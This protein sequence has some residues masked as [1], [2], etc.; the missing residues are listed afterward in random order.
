MNSIEIIKPDFWA[1]ESTIIPQPYKIYRF[2]SGGSRYYF[3]W[4]DKNL[5]P[6]V[7][8]SVT[9]VIKN[10][11]GGDKKH[12][13]K[14]YGTKGY[15]F[16]MRYLSD[17]AMYGTLMH[18]EINRIFNDKKY[19][20]SK[21]LSNTTEYLISNNIN[22]SSYTILDEDD[23][24]TYLKVFSNRLKNDLMAFMQFCYEV[25][26]Q[27]IASE[28]VL[29]SQE[30]GYAGAIDLVGYMDIDVKEFNGEY[31]KSGE[32]KGLPK[33]T[34]AK[35]RVLSIVD[36]KSGR[37]GFYKDHEWQLKM[38][39]SM[40]NENFPQFKVERIFNWSPNDWKITPTYKLKDQTVGINNQVFDCFIEYYKIASRNSIPMLKEIDDVVINFKENVFSGEN[41]IIHRRSLID[42]IKERFNQ[43]DTSTKTFT[44][45]ERFQLDEDIESLF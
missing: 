8:Q 26:F 2:N 11:I 32:K 22:P 45:E 27:P 6:L 40:W 16:C 12:L 36:F 1:S 18:I 28:L 44:E 13:L 23:E 24:D 42:A 4:E 35:K 38:Y 43:E 15:S 9:S 3:T 29:C 30:N 34:I 39:Q 10:F 7:Y 20:F 5:D 25:N 31:Y 17:A 33:E 41:S 19:D 21:L 14:W 37:K